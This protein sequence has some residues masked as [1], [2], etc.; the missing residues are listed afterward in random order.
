M[1]DDRRTRP[2]LRPKGEDPPPMQR[3]ARAS[4]PDP[5]PTTEPI[6]VQAKKAPPS[7]A[8]DPEQEILKALARLDQQHSGF[9]EKIKEHVRAVLV[10]ELPQPAPRAAPPSLT[11][12]QK[13]HWAKPDSSWIGHLPAILMAVAAL[14]TTVAQSCSTSQ[15]QIAEF[16]DKIDKIEKKVDTH[17]TLHESE[18][19]SSGRDQKQREQTLYHYQLA[20]RS[21][22]GGVLERLSV[23]V[24]D[25]SEAPPR[26]I[27]DFYPP[28]LHGSK[29]PQIQPKATF[30]APPKPEP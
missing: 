8:F 19:L 27:I 13:K 17:V 7:G 23:K 10:Q 22:V 12:E 1:A 5:P 11:P 3:P 30:P 20:E 15:K 16:A 26:A 2:T 18:K 25:E 9:E 29:A 14:V 28:P 21:Y 24:D 6:A 4:R